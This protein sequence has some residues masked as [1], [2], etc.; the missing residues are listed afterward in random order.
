MKLSTFCVSL[1][2]SCLAPAQSVLAA[3]PTQPN[4]LFIMVDDLG[5]DWIGC[6]G[7]DDIKTPRIDSLADGGIKFHNAWS[8][9]QCTPTRVTLLT[10]VCPTELR[11]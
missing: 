11:N 9:P 7:A 6:Y 10:G 3:E 1:V 2:I 5:K 4:I 8:M